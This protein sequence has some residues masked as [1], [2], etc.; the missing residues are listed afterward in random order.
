MTW[1]NEVTDPQT[2]R[3]GYTDIGGLPSRLTDLMAK[4]PSERSESMTAVGVL[5][6]IFAGHTLENDPLIAKG[7]DLLAAKLPRWDPASGDLDFYYWYYATLAMFQIGGARWDH[8]NEALKS[9]VVEHQRHNPDEDEF[10]S[11]D[12]LDPWSSV[13]GRVYSTAINCLS[14]EVYYRYPR[15]FGTVRKQH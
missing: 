6:R 7:A 13:G 9:A 11:W 12:P 5:A 3:T 15:V 4:F 8:W 2:G 1:I 14:M 10:G